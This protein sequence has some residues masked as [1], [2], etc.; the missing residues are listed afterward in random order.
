MPHYPINTNTTTF[1]YYPV[2]SDGNPEGEYSLAWRSDEWYPFDRET[3]LGKGME[4]MTIILAMRESDTAILLAADSAWTEHTAQGTIRS[5]SQEPKLHQL[6]KSP[7]MIG[8]ASDQGRLTTDFVNFLQSLSVDNWDDLKDTVRPFHARLHGDAKGLY[9]LA[10]KEFL[11]TNG[12]DGLLVG[13]IGGKPDIVEFQ[14]PGK[15]DSYWEEGF[16]AIGG[17]S[18][19]AIVV[20]QALK[21]VD[22]EP[23]GKLNRILDTLIYSVPLI[24]GPKVVWRV[25]PHGVEQL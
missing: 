8:T 12:L 19:F 16:H 21:D 11:S 10:R 24:K 15:T 2:D 18:G 6:G 4:A 9:E 22:M 5:P 7:L 23:L 20:Y 3:E 14:N 25:T 17:A 13:W 1:G